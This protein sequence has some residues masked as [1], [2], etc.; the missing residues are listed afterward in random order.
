MIFVGRAPRFFRT[1]KRYPH[2][3]TRVARLQCAAFNCTAHSRDQAYKWQWDIPLSSYII[4]IIHQHTSALGISI[5]RLFCGC[6]QLAVYVP[7]CPFQ[8]HSNK[9]TRGRWLTGE[10]SYVACSL[11]NDVCQHIFS[12]FSSVEFLEHTYI[13][14]FI[15]EEKLFL[16]KLYTYIKILLPI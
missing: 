5:I 2:P 6:L 3:L 9:L 8:A 16:D 4:G 15:S 12:Q 11:E 13:I 1:F 14:F 10:R 7:S